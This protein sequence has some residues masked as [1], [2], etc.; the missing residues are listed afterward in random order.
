MQRNSNSDRNL[1]TKL[2]TFNVYGGMNNQIQRELIYQ[3]MVKFKTDVMCLQEMRLNEELALIN[4]RNH[5]IYGFPSR[6]NN[7]HGKYSMGF[8]VSEKWTNY[9]N[10]DPRYIYDRI[11]KIAFNLPGRSSKIIKVVILNAYAPTM[12]IAMTNIREVEDFYLK[13]DIEYNRTKGNQNENFV[14]LCGD[15]NAKRRWIYSFLWPRKVKN[16][17]IGKGNSFLNI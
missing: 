15:L 13:L 17:R 6:N 5:A 8:I 14:F 7:P 12:Q 4:H 11:C 2:A 10:E 3:D 16:R 1:S 9:L